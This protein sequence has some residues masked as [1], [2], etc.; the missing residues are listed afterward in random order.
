MTASPKPS[1]DN[2][3]VQKDCEKI[4]DLSK[5]MTKSI[6]QLRSHLRQCDECP[7]YDDCPILQEVSQAVKAA[8]LAVNDEW[9][10]ASV[11]IH[12]SQ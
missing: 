5:D 8:I 4:I 10:L 6:R 2:C 7:D 11:I 9:N 3:P 1:K 12:N